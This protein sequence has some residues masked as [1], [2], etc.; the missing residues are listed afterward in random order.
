MQTTITPEIRKKAVELLREKGWCQGSFKDPGSNAICMT[1]ALR[2]AAGAETPGPATTKEDEETTI[3]LKGIGFD[4]IGA[5]C[6]WNNEVRR[7]IDDV[8][9]LILA[10]TSVS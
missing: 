4:N 2:F 6:R 10:G 8:I 5:A 7:T 1:A 9:D 3:L